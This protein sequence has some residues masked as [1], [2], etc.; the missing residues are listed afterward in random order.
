MTREPQRSPVS[1]AS[2]ARKLNLLLD[3][4]E[5]EG[6]KVA[7]NDVR[8]A[9]ASAGTPLSR[10]RWHYMRAGSGPA[11][12]QA[13]LLENLARFFGVNEDYLLDEGGEVPSKVEA[14]LDL[15]AS[16]RAAKIRSFAAR[17]MDGLSADTLR[18]IKDLL[19][20]HI[21]AEDP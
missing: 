2:L 15:L 7:F 5:A 1:G 13:P 19:D 14:Q 20:E 6:Q 9:M 4:A 11:V 21:S 17:Q 3:A 12:Q 16:M 8:D 10:A 18:Q